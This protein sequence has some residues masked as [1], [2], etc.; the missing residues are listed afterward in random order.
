MCLFNNLDSIIII[1]NYFNFSILIKIF[2]RNFFFLIM[3]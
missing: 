1:F 2:I 3:I